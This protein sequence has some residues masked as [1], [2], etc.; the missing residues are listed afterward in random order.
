MMV[1]CYNAYIDVVIA[2]WSLFYIRF[3]RHNYYT[4]QED[5]SIL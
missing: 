5:W 3:N 1:P 2:I 4:K